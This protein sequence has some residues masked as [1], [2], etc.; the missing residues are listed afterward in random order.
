MVGQIRAQQITKESISEKELNTNVLSEDSKPIRPMTL[1]DILGDAKQTKLQSQKDLE[2]AIN[3]A[4]KKIESALKIGAD[5]L[6]ADEESLRK[7]LAQLD[8]N[9]KHDFLTRLNCLYNQAKDELD[10]AL[11]LISTVLTGKAGQAAKDSLDKFCADEKIIKDEIKIL[12]RLFSQVIEKYGIDLKPGQAIAAFKKAIIEENL[13]MGEARKRKLEQIFE[14]YEKTI[15]GIKKG[16]LFKSQLPDFNLIIS[17]LGLRRPAERRRNTQQ[18]FRQRIQEAKQE[19]Q[20]D[21]FDMWQKGFSHL[22]AIVPG[23]IERA[24]KLPCLGG[25]YPSVIALPDRFQKIYYRHFNNLLVQQLLAEARTEGD[26]LEAERIDKDGQHLEAWETQKLC[27]ILG[28]AAEVTV[29]GQREEHLRFSPQG[30]ALKLPKI[31]IQLDLNEHHFQFLFKRSDQAAEELINVGGDGNCGIYA[32]IGAIHAHILQHQNLYREFL[33]AKWN[34]EGVDFCR[35]KRYE[36]AISLFNRSLIYLRAESDPNKETLRNILYN[37]GTSEF[38]V[39]E[40]ERAITHLTEAAQLMKTISRQTGVPVDGKYKR[41]LEECQKAKDGLNLSSSSSSVPEEQDEEENDEEALE[42][43]GQKKDE[44]PGA[45]AAGGSS[46]ARPA[47]SKQTSNSSLSTNLPQSSQH[48]DAI[49]QPAPSRS[50]SSIFNMA[51]Q[52]KV[53]DKVYDGYESEFPE[54]HKPVQSSK[55]KC[56]SDLSPTITMS[57]YRRIT[58]LNVVVSSNFG[59]VVPDEPVSGNEEGHSPK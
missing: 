31:R 12:T 9:R 11:S 46:T 54:R 45:G 50:S 59:V 39:G 19:T 44:D 42:A 32:V 48:R 58:G 24:L 28:F 20:N 53:L 15:L 27:E 30:I 51:G 49:S 4:I 47:D 23:F 34:K 55:E 43:K 40:Y 22:E 10:K 21:T 52:G 29:W 38:H 6:A 1:K 18:E 56:K 7:Q 8:I 16:Y 36:Q 2:D 13:I 25:K 35:A 5:I 33:I 14:A 3:K 41:R 37:L 26:V 17:K 57:Q